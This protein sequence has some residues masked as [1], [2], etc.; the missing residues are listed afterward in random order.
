MT[1]LGEPAGL[2][3][4]MGPAADSASNL[5]HRDRWL[6]GL[7]V[8]LLG[9]ILRLM[10]ATFRLTSVAGEEHLHRLV[11]SGQPAVLA[12][13][14]E[15]VVVC[16]HYFEK[17][18]TKKGIPVAVL[19][20]LSRDGEL[21]ARMAQRAGIRVERGSASRGGL[22]GLRR[23]YRAISRE[24]CS[25]AIAPDGPRGPA[26]EC[27]PGTV[28]LAQI[29]GAPILPLACAAEHAWRLRSWDRM[30]VPR[31][32]SRIALAFGEPMPIPAS[33]STEELLIHT[34]RLGETLDCLVGQAE[35]VFWGRPAAGSGHS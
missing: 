4:A 2:D 1:D 16:S 9:W 12:G 29:S 11:G 19:V 7:A 32:F 35:S 6:V 34:R 10:A 22:H 17:H 30:I 15:G 8:A 3:S 25:V 24:R 14:H 31:P 27:K 13:W 18:L 26:R 23:L 5:S 28:L 20:S 33:S 21:L